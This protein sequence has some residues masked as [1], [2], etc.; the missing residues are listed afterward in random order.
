MKKNF[1]LL[2]KKASMAFIPCVSRSVFLLLYDDGAQL[3]AAAAFLGWSKECCCCCLCVL[4]ALG[5][6]TEDAIAKK[7]FQ[8]LL[9]PEFVS[10]LFVAVC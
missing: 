2:K 7:L 5:S 6:I 8:V 1:S 3:F 10:L 4:T 9:L